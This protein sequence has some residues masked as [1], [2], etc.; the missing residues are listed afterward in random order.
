MTER[1]LSILECGRFVEFCSVPDYYLWTA[2]RDQTV[3][4]GIEFT[5]ANGNL[6][7]EWL[8]AAGN[9]LISSESNTDNESL[10]WDVRAGSVYLAR[11]VGPQGWT[12]DYNLRISTEERTVGDIDLDGDVDDQDID[13]LHAAMSITPILEIAELD[14]NGIVHFGDADR[15]IEGILDTRRGDADLNGQI[16]FGDFL[17]VSR[18]FGGPAGWS[19]GDWTGDGWARFDDFLLLSRN[20]GW[21]RTPRFQTA[22]QPS[23]IELNLN[24]L[25]Y[26]DGDMVK[27]TLDF[28]DVTPPTGM[29]RVALSASGSGDAEPVPLRQVAPGRYESAN[30]IPISAAAEGTH[31]NGSFTP[32]A[33]ETFYAMYF[34]EKENGDLAGVEEDVIFDFGIMRGST[35]P[36]TR[37]AVAP[38]IAISADELGTEPGSRPSGTL[39]S[40]EGFVQIATAEVLLYASDA[41]DLNTFFGYYRG[42]RLGHDSGS[43]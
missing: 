22:E 5:H 34:A 32:N 37:A 26:G 39:A 28:H 41:A 19:T 43:G 27:L 30:P 24:A 8:D 16:D 20:F 4:V 25:F 36:S 38:S 23:G 7:L 1:N 42:N 13:E 18:G 2:D 11:V 14:H 21:Q 6:N 10:S 12:N 31:S 29:P 3:N 35:D 15:L 33:G 9:L 40:K 17:A